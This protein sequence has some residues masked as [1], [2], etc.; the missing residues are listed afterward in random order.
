M[1]GEGNGV[2]TAIT[3]EPVPTWRLVGG[4]TFLE[5]S[6]E[7]TPGSTDTT[8]LQQHGDSPRHQW[9]LRSAMTLPHAVDFDV[10]VRF[11]DELPNQRVAAYTTCD[12]HLSWRPTPILELAAV[13]TNLFDQRHAEFGRPLTRREV[14]RSVYGKVT[15]RF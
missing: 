2:E 8:Q 11:V 10:H 14:K 6:L 7:A 9:F 1:K 12:A 3:F 15:C 13:G 5:L 4:H